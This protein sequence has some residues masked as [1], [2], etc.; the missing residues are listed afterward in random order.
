M[1][2]LGQTGFDARL[3]DPNQ[4]VNA[5]GRAIQGIG[6]GLALYRQGQQQQQQQQIAQ[7]K[8]Q[9]LGQA[10]AEFSNAALSGDDAGASAAIARIA[11]IEP[12]PAKIKQLIDTQRGQVQAQLQRTQ[13]QKNIAQTEQ[14]RRE[15]ELVGR[16][17]PIQQERLDID[18]Q[19]LRLREEEASLRRLEQEAAKETNALRREELQGKIDA[20]QQ[21]L[22]A[23]RLKSENEQKE[24]TAKV[25]KSRGLASEAAQLAREIAGDDRLDRITGSRFYVENLPTSAASQDLV[26]KAQRLESLL[27]YENL[28]LMS[29]VLTDRDIQFLGRIGSGLNV[30]EGGIAGTPEGTRQ[31]LSDIASKIDSALSADSQGE[32][33]RQGAAEQEQA[34][35]PKVKTINWSDL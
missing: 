35:T 8:Q 1:A 18:R 15:T 14:I 23:D 34:E 22:E 21:K 9:A 24:L 20:R 6:Q 5:L 33:Q 2:I 32:E 29:G 12:D 17:D 26:N 28:G 25:E 11:Q 10:V 19:K 16:P 7:Q 30:L 13:A 31:R 3:F 27:T 4:N